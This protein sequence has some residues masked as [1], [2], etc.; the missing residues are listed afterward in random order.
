[1]NQKNNTTEDNSNDAV[2]I[3][4]DANQKLIQETAN[5]FQKECHDCYRAVVDDVKKSG[6]IAHYPDYQDSLAL[7]QFH[8][9]AEL[10]VAIWN[11]QNKY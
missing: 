10:Q 7:W 1:M 11:L 2:S 5:A 4:L 8:K 9:L 6:K 3:G